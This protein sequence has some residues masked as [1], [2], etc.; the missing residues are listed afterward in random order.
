MDIA[1]DHIVT[2]IVMTL[3]TLYALF[4]DDL[5]VLITDSSGDSIFWVLNIICMVLFFL[6]IVLSSIAKPEYFNSFF[7]YL[8]LI[9]TLSL[10]LDIGWISNSLFG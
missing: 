5:R 10:I 8:D 7:F 1:L 9:S 3:I 6:E 4:G 2:T